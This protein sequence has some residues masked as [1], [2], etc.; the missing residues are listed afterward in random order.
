M[1]QPSAATSNVVV[2][3]ASRIAKSAVSGRLW[4]LE[5]KAMATMEK[6]MPSC[7]SMIQPR[8]LPQKWEKPGTL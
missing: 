5:V 7:D 3:K 4:S 6:K 1:R 2:Q 8:R